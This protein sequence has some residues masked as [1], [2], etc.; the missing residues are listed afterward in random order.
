VKIAGAN[1]RILAHQSVDDVPGDLS[2]P[3][4]SWDGRTPVKDS[5]GG[6]AHHLF[7]NSITAL[8]LTEGF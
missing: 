4:W 1:T 2:I 8:T 6:P 3:R 5:T 7:G